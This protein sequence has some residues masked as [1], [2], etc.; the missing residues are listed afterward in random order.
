VSKRTADH[1]TFIIDRH[2]PASPAQ[3]FVAWSQPAAKAHWFAGPE[4]WTQL[5]RE[6]EAALR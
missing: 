5:A 1:S 4:S 6:L 3:V 2:F